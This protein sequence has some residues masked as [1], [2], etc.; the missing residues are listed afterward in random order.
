MAAAW[1]LAWLVLGTGLGNLRSPGSAN[2]LDVLKVSLGIAAAIGAGVALV[3]NYRR[4]RYLELDF[5]GDR[6]RAHSLADRYASAAQQLGAEQPA[7]RLAGVYAMAHLADDW[8]EQRQQCADVLCAYLRIPPE[9]ANRSS[10]VALG[11]AHILSPAE[12]EVRATLMKVVAAHL[13]P[14]SLVDWS[15]LDFDFDGAVLPRVEWATVVV[16]GRATFDGAIFTEDVVLQDSRFG[17][18]LRLG[19]ATFS[20]P[21]SFRGM[22]VRGPCDLTGAAFNKRVSFGEAAVDFLDCTRARFAGP[23]GFD[24]VTFRGEAHFHNSQFEEGSFFSNSRFEA[25]TWFRDASFAGPAW[26]D[27]IHVGHDIWFTEAEFQ[28][29]ASFGGA[30]FAATA[31]F[32]AATF[33]GDANFEKAAFGATAR[34]PAA[35]F[36]QEANFRAASVGADVQIQEASF[37]QGLPD[38]LRARAS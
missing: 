4:Q 27:G 30:V 31:G 24:H 10:A 25:E 5:A 18:G 15:N 35:T 14:A 17:D 36:A 38:A 7:V 29:E 28:S 32:H 33:L 22:D 16:E 2:F 21:T 8:H 37:A 13:V 11:S 26:F 23:A 19:G 20:G 34:F 12:R 9:V 3:V 6:E 1:F